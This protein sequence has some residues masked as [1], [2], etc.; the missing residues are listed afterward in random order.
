M[1]EKRDKH[2]QVW[3]ET[4]IYT[5]IGLAV[6]GI[7]LGVS[8]PKIDAMKDKLLIEQTIASLNEIN[9]RIYDVQSAPGNKRI[10]ELKI[11]K[12]RLFLDS[13]SN[14]IRW[15]IDSVYKYSEPGQAV[16]SGNLVIITEGSG[17]YKVKLSIVYSLN[18]SYKQT[19]EVVELDGSPTPYKLTIENRGASATSPAVNVDLSTV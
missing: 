8:K 3:I 17:P 16:P 11:S 9:A 2:A 18:I 19:E 7:L 15:E 14:E 13:F 6:I 10:L 12:G 5:L 1:N 4:V